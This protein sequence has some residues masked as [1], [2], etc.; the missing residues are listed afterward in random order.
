[1]GI[2]AGLFGR[3]ADRK[4]QKLERN[5]EEILNALKRKDHKKALALVKNL[6][7]VYFQEYGDKTTLLT[8]SSF[9]GYA[10]IC[11]MM[12]DKGANVNVVDTQGRTALMAAAQIGSKEVVKLLLDN[13]AD[14]FIETSSGTTALK[15]AA[16]I[17]SKEVVDLIV[18]N[19]GGSVLL[20]D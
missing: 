11:K 1:M 3:S 5:A 9:V 7:S 10:D 2:I 8:L 6:D 4:A 20:W 18:E 19:E 16:K 14:A 12:I 15:I 13:G 17:G